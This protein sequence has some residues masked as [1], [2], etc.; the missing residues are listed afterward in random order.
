MAITQVVPTTIKPTG[1]TNQAMRT[2]AALGVEKRRAEAMER[3]KARLAEPAKGEEP[4][5]I[6]IR[7]GDIRFAD[8]QTDNDR[9]DEKRML[10]M[11][12]TWDW[13]LYTP[14]TVSIRPGDATQTVWCPDGRHRVT[15]ILTRF[16]ADYE[17]EPILHR[18]TYEQEAWVFKHQDDNRK[19][20][21]VGDKW[22]AGLKAGETDDLAIAAL[23]QRL[24]IALGSK[25]G[26]HTVP[27]NSFIGLCGRHGIPTVECALWLVLDRWQGSAKSMSYPFVS[28]VV[29]F[30]HRY[31]EHPAFQRDALLERLRKHSVESI[32]ELASSY[33]VTPEQKRIALALR[34]IH[35]RKNTVN[36]LP[37]WV[38]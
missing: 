6:R 38:K 22:A 16:G 29:L 11:A 1:Y 23:V 19:R 30:V 14:P 24:G 8:Y 31:R 21:S 2:L 37:E 9:Y 28:G 15:A 5:T 33:N 4:A 17:I 26:E 12:A 32:H 10:D 3:L 35:N 20:V 34:A 27:R 7:V 18:L 25:A 36:V 13:D